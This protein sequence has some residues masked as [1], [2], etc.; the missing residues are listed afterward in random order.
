MYICSPDLGT[1]QYRW[2]L[3]GPLDQTNLVL[4]GDNITLMQRKITHVE[5][6]HANADHFDCILDNQN[7]FPT[8]PPQLD[9]TRVFINID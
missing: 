2:L 8:S 3:H 7:H 1:H 9:D 6:C 4:E 5:L